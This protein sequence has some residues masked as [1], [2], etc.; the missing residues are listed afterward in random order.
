MAVVKNIGNRNV[1]IWTKF[2]I[3]EIAITNA[4]YCLDDRDR[5]V[6]AQRPRVNQILLV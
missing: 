2:K 4:L 5:D 3:C 6:I 1:D